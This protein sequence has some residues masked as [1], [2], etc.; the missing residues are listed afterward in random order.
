MFFASVIGR[1][2]DLGTVKVK[3][4]VASDVTSAFKSKQSAKWSFASAF[5]Y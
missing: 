2:C 1:M 3:S 5:S 4:I